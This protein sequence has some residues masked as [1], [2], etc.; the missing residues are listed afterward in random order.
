MRKLSLILLVSL[1]LLVYAEDERGVVVGS[2]DMKNSRSFSRNLT[3]PIRKRR[4]G[5][6]V[7]GG[8]VDRVNVG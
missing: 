4:I 8:W 1:V 7:E 3:N 5:D 6:L 2:A